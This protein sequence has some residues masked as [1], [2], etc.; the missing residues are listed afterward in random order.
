[1]ALETECDN[2]TTTDEATDIAIQVDE[3]DKFICD[4]VTVKK[5]VK[6]MRQA[7]RAAESRTKSEEKMTITIKKNTHLE[8]KFFAKTNG[9]KLSEAIDLLLK[10]V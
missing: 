6:K 7:I 4:N 8:L 3:L 10:Q 9:V 2:V 1:L 5:D